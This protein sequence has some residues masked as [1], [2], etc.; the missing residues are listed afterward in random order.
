[1]CRPCAPASTPVSVTAGVLER[2]CRTRGCGICVLLGS[3]ISQQ[4]QIP[5]A[6]LC[7]SGMLQQTKILYVVLLCT[8]L[9]KTAECVWIFYFCWISAPPASPTFATDQIPVGGL[10]TWQALMMTCWAMPCLAAVL[11]ACGVS[12][13]LDQGL[14]LLLCV[15]VGA[16]VYAM[17]VPERWLPGRFDFLLSSHQ[18][19]HGRLAATLVLIR[20]WRCC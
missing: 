3:L 10:P 4:T 6:A 8:G 13:C 1:M 11:G 16:L 19:F 17:R 5:C 20:L 2:T 9:R 12:A 14:L 7:I 18:I 15:Q